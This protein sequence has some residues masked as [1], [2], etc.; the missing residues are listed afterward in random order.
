MDFAYV[1]DGAVLAKLK[2]GPSV[3]IEDADDLF[4]LDVTDVE[5]HNFYNFE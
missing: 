1:K 5:Y 3:K 4:K 2:R